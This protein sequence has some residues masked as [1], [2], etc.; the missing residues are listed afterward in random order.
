MDIESVMQGDVDIFSLLTADELD[1]LEMRLSEH[2]NAIGDDYG[3]YLYD[4]EKDRI[5]EGRD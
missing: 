1:N 2:L 3:D 4:Q 5:A